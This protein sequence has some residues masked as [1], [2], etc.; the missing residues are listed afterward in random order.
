LNEQLNRFGLGSP[1]SHVQSCALRCDLE[2]GIA[3]VG[4][5]NGDTEIEEAAEAIDI[6]VSG[7]LCQH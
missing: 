2:I 7:K 4:R 5:V 6:P 3:A 1:R